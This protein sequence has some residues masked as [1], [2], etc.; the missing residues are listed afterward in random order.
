[1]PETVASVGAAIWAS[2][3]FINSL[4]GEAALP[5]P[6]NVI[7]PP[8]SRTLQGRYAAV[9][10]CNELG[11][12]PSLAANC[13]QLFARIQVAFTPTTAVFRPGRFKRSVSTPL[14]ADL[15]PS[16]KH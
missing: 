6:E 10:F 15:G 13:C 8:W 5:K 14:V 3:G 11:K 2:M 12:A 1:M 7:A 4:H 16:H 9:T